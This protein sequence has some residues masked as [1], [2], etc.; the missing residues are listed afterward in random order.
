MQ[1]WLLPLCLIILSG[2]AEFNSVEKGQF[3]VGNETVLDKKTDLMWAASDNTESLTWQEAV[4]YCNAYSGGGFQD[5]R[6]PKKTELQAL[7]KSNIKKEGKMINLSS[8][9]VWASETD[10][11]K[12]AF[13]DFNARGCSWM[14]Q[15]LSISLRALPVRDPKAAVTVYPSPSPI[16]TPQSMEQRLQVLG[17]LHKQQLITEDEY[18]RKKTA[19]LDE[20]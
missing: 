11:S 14:E 9:L 15:V 5:W 3:T 18:N 19:I 16:V 4:A 1:T 7:I 20:L 12:G 17:L 8:N 10:D 13:C 6:M 2:C